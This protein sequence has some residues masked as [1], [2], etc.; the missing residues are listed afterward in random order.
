MLQKWHQF[1]ETALGIPG[2]TVYKSGYPAFS[3]T[4]LV[5]SDFNFLKIVYFLLIVTLNLIPEN[6]ILDLMIA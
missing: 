4:W 3:A 2:L 5:K 6:V 1:Q